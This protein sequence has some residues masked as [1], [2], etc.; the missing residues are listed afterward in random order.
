M[1]QIEVIKNETP[2]EK[3]FGLKKILDSGGIVSSLLIMREN[4]Y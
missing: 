2:P 4:R 3:E 1:P